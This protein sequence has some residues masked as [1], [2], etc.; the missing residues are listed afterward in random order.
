MRP[1]PALCALFS[2]G[3]GVVRR[4]LV[5]AAEH[6]AAA[7]ALRDRLVGL[8]ALVVGLAAVTEADDLRLRTCR[9]HGDR[10]KRERDDKELAGHVTPSNRFAKRYEPSWPALP[11]AYSKD[12]LRSQA[13][14]SLSRLPDILVLRWCLDSPSGSSVASGHECRGPRSNARY[15][16]CQTKAAEM[17]RGVSLAPLPRPDWAEHLPHPFLTTGRS[18]V[19][20]GVAKSPLDRAG[21]GPVARP[22]GR[23]DMLRGRLHAPV[24]AREGGRR[25]RGRA[26]ASDS[27]GR[28]HRGP[29]QRRADTP[30]WLRAS[31]QGDINSSATSDRCALRLIAARGWQGR[32]PSRWAAR[33]GERRGHRV[34]ELHGSTPNGGRM[35]PSS[36]EGGSAEAPGGGDVLRARLRRPRTAWRA[37]LVR[38]PGRRGRAAW[39]PRASRSLR[40][41]TR[42]RSSSA[43][44]ASTPRRTSRRASET[45]RLLPTARSRWATRPRRTIS[46]P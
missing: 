21:R 41:A 18:R 1:P 23:T 27:I 31:P 22:G 12:D 6:D 11:Y 39:R 36:T 7:G 30:T 43:I 25:A 15:P 46:R 34:R 20:P 42:A 45:R 29:M 40:A 38:R 19:N 14:G 32:P 8:G 24:P 13:V 33:A 10:A 16:S 3:V 9:A 4:V 37:P 5:A 44:R 28:E 17:L 35:R 26:L 2:V